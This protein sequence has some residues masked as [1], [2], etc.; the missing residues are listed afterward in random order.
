MEQG[1]SHRSVAVRGDRIVARGRGYGQVE[2]VGIGTV[3]LR[4]AKKRPDDRD[5]SCCSPWSRLDAPRQAFCLMRKSL[6]R[7]LIEL[8]SAYHL[9]SL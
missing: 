1:G 6:S 2:L 7:R 3:G 9:Y 8:S 4:I 5:L